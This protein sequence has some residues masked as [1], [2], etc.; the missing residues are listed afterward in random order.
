MSYPVDGLVRHTAHVELS[1]LMAVDDRLEDLRIEI[2][3]LLSAALA[4]DERH[5]AELERRDLLHVAETARRDQLHVDEM[6][7]RD[8]LHTH[9]M[10]LI[11]EALETRDIIGQAKG[12]IMAAM[13]CSA[14]QAFHL[15]RQ[16]S[17][18]ENRKLVE[19]AIEIAERPAMHRPPAAP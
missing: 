10:A 9:E 17:Q 11:R 15:L 19:V 8:D 1:A 7:R 16:Q 13:S 4:S 12:I 2:E 3:R 6:Q 5:E 18:H 14:D